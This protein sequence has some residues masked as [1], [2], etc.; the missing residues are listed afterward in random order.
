MDELPADAG[1]QRAKYRS[2]VGYL[3]R[4]S[5]RRSFHSSSVALTRAY[6]HPGGGHGRVLTIPS[7]RLLGVLGT[8]EQEAAGNGLP[9]AP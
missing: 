6:T 8:V 9:G 3:P 4:A 2:D 1:D 5:H 7:V